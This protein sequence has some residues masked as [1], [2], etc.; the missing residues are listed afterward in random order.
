MTGE[1]WIDTV[2]LARDFGTIRELLPPWVAD[3]RDLPYPLY[4]ALRHAGM[5]ISWEENLPEEEMPPK[6]IWTD[7][8][9]LTEWFEDVKRK[10]DSQ[11]RGD[12]EIEDPRDN[13]A[14]G[15]LIHG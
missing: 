15:A 12:K 9:A 2:R 11:M 13:E 4:E 5:V 10:R 7:M 6:R 1:A 8:D 3:V 14:A